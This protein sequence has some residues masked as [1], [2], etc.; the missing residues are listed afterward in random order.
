MLIILILLIILIIL[1]ILI[2]IAFK[3][4]IILKILIISIILKIS[5][6]NYIILIIKKKTK[7]YKPK[8]AFL[9]IMRIQQKNQ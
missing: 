5:I 3:I 1:I 4:L 2:L 8:E 6:T 9:I 7:T